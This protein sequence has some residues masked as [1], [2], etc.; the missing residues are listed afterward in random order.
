MRHG[1]RSR[2]RDASLS[3]SCIELRGNRRRHSRAEAT[4]RSGFDAMYGEGVD[5]AV[6]ERLLIPGRPA[7]DQL[8][9]RGF[10]PHRKHR[11]R[12]AFGND[13][14]PI[15]EKTSWLQMAHE[16]LDALPPDI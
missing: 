16:V 5:R 15:D 3:R 14:M 7:F 1:F 12:A 6:G 8:Q 4:S 10:G 9:A 2:R 11:R 13:R